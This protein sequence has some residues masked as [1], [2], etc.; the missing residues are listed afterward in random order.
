M[1]TIQKEQQ[2]MLKIDEVFL[3]YLFAIQK[4]IHKIMN[5]IVVLL[6][7]SIL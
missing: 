2:T 5:R 4:C 6:A 3:F 1:V 7:P